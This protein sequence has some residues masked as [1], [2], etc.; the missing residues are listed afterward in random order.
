RIAV[1]Y[2]GKIVEMG[3]AT[4]VA[5][6]RLHPYTEALFAAAPRLAQ[7]GRNEERRRLALA[8]EPP[9]PSKPP[10][11]CAFHPR[12]PIAEKGVCDVKAPELVELGSDGH[13]VACFKVE[14][15]R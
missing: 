4:A 1:M 12:C 14:P 9:H 15:A 11:G 6:E 8:G 5:R 7:A 3:P 10:S 2:L 13:Q